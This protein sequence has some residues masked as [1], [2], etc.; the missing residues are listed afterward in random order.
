MLATGDGRLGPFGPGLG[1][2]AACTTIICTYI[3]AKWQISVQVCFNYFRLVQVV[4]RGRQNVWLKA[5]TKLIKTCVTRFD[6]RYGDGGE[7]WRY[8]V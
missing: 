6:K 8:G 1:P 5:I 4:L 7:Y 2:G 3:E